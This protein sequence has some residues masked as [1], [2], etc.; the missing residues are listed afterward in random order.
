[1]LR[2]YLDWDV[3]S[4]LKLEPSRPLLEFLAGHKERILVPFTP[5]HFSD[6]MKSYKGVNPHFDND[7]EMLGSICGRHFMQWKDHQIEPLLGEPREYFNHIKNEQPLDWEQLLDMDKLLHEMDNATTSMG[8]PR[9]GT[10]MKV[11]L[12]SPPVGLVVNGDSSGVMNQLFPGLGPNSTAWDIIKGMAPLAKGMLDGPGKWKELRGSIKSDGFSVAAI[13]GNSTAEEAAVRI[14]SFLKSKHMGVTFIEYV[15]STFKHDKEPPDDYEFFTRAY[16]MLDMIGYKSD[17][18]PKATNSMMNV[19]QDAEHAFYAAHCDY[20]VAFDK[21]LRGKA[22]LLYH[23]LNIPTEVILPDELEQKATAR[24]HTAPTDFVAA[25]QDAVTQSRAGQIVEQ[26]DPSEHLDTET[27]GI[28]LPVLYLNFFTHVVYQ[29]YKG[30]GIALTFRKVF[31]NFSRFVY[32]TESEAVLDC[33]VALFGL[34]D[35][36]AY[37]EKKR[38]FVYGDKAPVFLW[39]FPGGLIKIEREEDTHRPSL[40]FVLA[41]QQEPG[42]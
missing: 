17:K 32:Y 13:T 26:H 14:D 24:F 33:M 3:I 30:K 28:K 21:K 34:D 16:L 1:M 15:E 36:A 39:Q 11:L 23:L 40:T 31:K 10:L 7:L 6:L 35:K 19:W 20:L 12:Q 8:L 42:D 37:S 4:K 27:L 22:A 29:E 25:V 38:E 18:L 9:L 5:T 41:V 2:V